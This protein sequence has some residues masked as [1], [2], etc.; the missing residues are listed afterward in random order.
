MKER[1]VIM[2]SVKCPTKAQMVERLIRTL[3]GK[4]ERVNTYRGKRRWLETFPQLVKSYNGTPHTSLPKGM[5]PND[6]KVE[7][8]KEVWQYLYGDE[9]LKTSP[10]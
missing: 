5:S 10:S 6:V 3:R 9:L 8:E 7:N 2:F 1:D 4:Q